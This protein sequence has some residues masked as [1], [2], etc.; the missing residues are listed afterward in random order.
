MATPLVAGGAA[1]VR[2]YYQKSHGHEA[3]AALVKATLINSAVDM[4]DENNDGSHDFVE[5]TTGL[6]TGDSSIY[7]YSVTG[8]EPFKVSLVWSDHPATEFITATFFT[9]PYSV[10]IDISPGPNLVNDLD[11]VVTDPAGQT[12]IGNDFSGGWT[13]PGGSDADRLNNV[14]NVYVDN[15]STGEWTVTVTGYNVPMGGRQPFALV[16]DGV[17]GSAEPPPAADFSGTPTSGDAPQMVKFSDTSTGTVDTWDWNFG[18][19]NTSSLQNPDHSYSGAGNYTVSLAIT[20]PGGTSFKTKTNYVSITDPAG[21]P[22]PPPTET[23]TITKA[24]YS[25]RRDRLTVEA[26]SSEGGAPALT[27]TYVVGGTEY[28]GNAMEYNLK[29]DKW[30]VDVN[31]VLS[32]PNSA[33]VC[34]TGTTN[35]AT[36]ESIGGK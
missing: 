17:V 1:L 16:V 25:S 15:P 14:E 32:K 22:P 26:T 29:K 7:T 13:L 28:A 30:K 3:S 9:P 10:E 23:I 11:L 35:C 31:S 20:G 18:D 34:F 6:G 24:N 12:Y 21:T 19:S 2:D 33:K 8:S 27:M 5:E 4:Q 36:T